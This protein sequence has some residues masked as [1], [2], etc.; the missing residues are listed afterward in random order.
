M[1]AHDLSAAPVELPSGRQI[2]RKVAMVAAFLAV[3]AVVATQLPG[4]SE[5][6]HQLAGA[7][8]N[9]IAAALILELLST[10]AF[11]L[12]FHCV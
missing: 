5:I 3:G 4:L 12:A 8:T 2:A 10:A 7:D 9:W 6:G 1:H 11:A